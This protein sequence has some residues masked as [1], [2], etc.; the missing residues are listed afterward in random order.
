M[1]RSYRTP[2]NLLRTE[3]IPVFQETLGATA[4]LMSAEDY[5]QG[6]KTEFNNEFQRQMENG[7]Y[8]VRRVEETVTVD[9]PAQGS[10]NASLGTDQKQYGD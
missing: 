3:L 8:I 4:A 9:E 6:G 1:A 10:A 2:E 7:I 5:F